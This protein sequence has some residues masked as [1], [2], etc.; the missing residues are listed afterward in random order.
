VLEKGVATLNIGPH[1]IQAT[2]AAMAWARQAVVVKQL[3]GTQALREA[4]PDALRIFRHYF[5]QQ[6]FGDTAGAANTIL[7]ALGGYRH[8]RLLVELYNE[9]GQRLGQGLREHV[10]WTYDVTARLHDA[11]V[12]VAGFSFSTGNPGRDDWRYL[13]DCDFAC[14]DVLALHQYWG[15]QGFTTDHALRHRQVHDWLGG[16]HPP[17]VITECGRDAVEG[18]KG[19]WI[20]DGVSASQYVSELWAYGH[21]IACDQYVSG[22][23]VF[24]AGPTE[25]WL[26]FSADNLD[27]RALTVEETPIEEAHVTSDE[28][29]RWAQDVW[30][31]AGVPYNKDAGIVHYWLDSAKRGHYLGRPE[32]PEHKTE[33]GVYVLQEFSGAILHCKVGEWIVSEGLPPFA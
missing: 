18:G 5:P 14:V 10:G 30:H 4:R 13:A 26:A 23:A 8:P 24:T 25:D 9:V 6:T 27:V 32:G 22:A 16:Q 3:D 7:S 33:N 31:R 29:T 12:Q 2:P 21:E 20:R 11:G 19:G 28:F 1:I 15:G 17:F